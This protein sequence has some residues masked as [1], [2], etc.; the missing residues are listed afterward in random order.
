MLD[1]LNIPIVTSTNYLGVL[2]DS[3]LNFSNHLELNSKLSQFS[4]I[5]WKISFKLNI[6]AA[7]TFYFS[8]IFS[9]LSYGIV[10]CGGVLMTYKCPR[11]HGFFKRVTCNLFAWY[12]P[13]ES[14]QSL[15]LKLGLLMPVDIYKFNIMTIYINIRQGHYLPRLKFEPKVLDYSDRRHTELRVPFPRKNAMKIS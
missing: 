13:G 7:K 3:K 6:N 9:L 12:F 1:G 4:G 2:I 8:F 10:A 11:L 5:A 15:C 14:F